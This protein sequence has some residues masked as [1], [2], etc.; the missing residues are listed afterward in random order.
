MTWESLGQTNTTKV[1]LTLHLCHNQ[2]KKPNLIFFYLKSV[3]QFGFDKK[4]C[5][6]CKMYF[7]YTVTL[8]L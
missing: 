7:F 4:W 1:N 6:W 8:I 5:S 3:N 2:N